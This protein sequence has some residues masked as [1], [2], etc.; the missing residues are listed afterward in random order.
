MSAEEFEDDSTFNHV[1][2][3]MLAFKK[4]TSESETDPLWFRYMDTVEIVWR[5]IKTEQSENWVVHHPAPRDML[6]YIAASEPHL[7]TKLGYLYLQTVVKLRKI[8]LSLHKY[9]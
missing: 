4:Q 2:S 1:K 9:F 6:P 8:I 7:Y 5:F 3:A